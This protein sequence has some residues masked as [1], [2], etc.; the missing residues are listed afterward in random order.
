MNRSLLVQAYRV[1]DRL[2]GIPA[3]LVETVIAG[4]NVDQ[5]GGRA[6]TF[7]F[8][9]RQLPVIDVRC[10][11]GL[12][13]SSS[14]ETPRFVVTIGEQPAVLKVDGFHGILELPMDRVVAADS[15]FSTESSHLEGVVQLLGGLLLVQDTDKMVNSALKK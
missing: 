1:D 6:A 7:E 5:K 2:V 3:A 11:L 15:G 10:L 13:N 14:P 4:E 8:N 12:P 9:G